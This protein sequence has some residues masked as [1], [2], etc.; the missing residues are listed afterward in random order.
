LRDT[1]ECREFRE[2]LRGLDSVTDDEVRERMRSMK[3]QVSQAIHGTA[4]KV[5][6]L[7][8]ATGIGLIPVAGA[9]LGPAASAM[10]TFLVERVLPRSGPL[11]FLDQLLPLLRDGV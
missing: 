1:P 5:L 2:W 11:A 9:V 6:R 10:D 7:A 3:A 4:G 8:V